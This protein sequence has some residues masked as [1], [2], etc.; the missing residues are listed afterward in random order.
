M[1]LLKILTFERKR[2][3]TARQTKKCCKEAAREI[4]EF[5]SCNNH[6]P[7]FKN[8]TEIAGAAKVH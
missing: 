3:F 7:L 6:L 1:H 2:T 5:P 4:G 8:E